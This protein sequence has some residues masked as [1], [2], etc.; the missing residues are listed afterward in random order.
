MKDKLSNG[1][2]K[3]PLYNLPASLHI[4]SLDQDLGQSRG[5][6]LLG[7]LPSGHGLMLQGS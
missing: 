3:T 2:P 5:R 1:L 4:Q 7:H 6:R